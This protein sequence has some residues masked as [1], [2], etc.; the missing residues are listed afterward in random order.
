[1]TEPNY[2]LTYVE[3]DVPYCTLTYGASPCEATLT[4][5]NPTGTIK[6][7]NGLGTCQDRANFAESIVTLRFAQPADYLPVNDIEAIASIASVSYSPAVISLG[8]DLGQRASLKVTMVDHPHSDT[9]P[10]FDKYLSDRPYD[11][12]KLGTFWGKFRARHPYLRGRS[13]RLIQGLLGQ[14]LAEMDTRHFLIEQFDGPGLDGQFTITAKDALK[15]ADGDRAQA[16]MLSKGYLTAGITNSATSASLSPSGIGSEYPSSGYINVGGKEIVAF[17]RSGDA[18][19]LTRARFN[20]VAV[21][22]DAGDRCQLCLHYSAEDPADIIKDLMVTYAGVPSGYINIADWQAETGAYYRRVNTALIPEPTSVRTLLSELIEQDGLALWWDDAAETIRLQV[23]RQ[24]ATDAEA[25]SD[26]NVVRDTLKVR[27]QPGKRISQIWTYFG[28]FNPLNGLDPDNFRSAAILGDL[29]AE[30]DYGQP[31]IKKIFSRWIPFGGL[32]IANRVNSIQL[33]RYRTAP[34]HFTFQIFR[35]GAETPT[36]GEGSRLQGLPMQEA[37]GDLS[38]VPV[39]ITR[40]RPDDDIWEIE[41]E[42]QAFT[43][44]TDEDLSIH[45]ITID[46]TT[47]NVNLRDLHDDLYPTPVAGDEVL[48]IVNSGVNIGSVSTS[49]PAFDVG[50]WPSQAATGNRTSG[51]AVISSINIDV[52]AHPIEPGMFV[53]G[54]GIPNGT[55][56]LTVDSAHQV[57]LDANATSSGTGGAL[58]FYTVKITLDIRGRIQGKGGRGADGRAGGDNTYGYTGGTGGPG[59]YSRYP[60]TLAM[61]GYAAGGGGGGGGGGTDY[62]GWIG[63]QYNGGGGG[64][65]AGLGD[66]GNGATSEAGQPGDWT[67]G[68]I[69]GRNAENASGTVTLRAD[70]AGTGGAPGT[71]GGSAAG[72]FPGSG[73]PA[74]ASVDGWSYVKEGVVTGAYQGSKIN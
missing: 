56:V 38:S 42:E 33:A 41:A 70:R 51:S 20:T 25:Y 11:P 52:V 53:R 30:E 66:L 69:G 18:L 14:T 39:Q 63:P 32:T 44:T 49:L 15:L 46:S 65:G 54:T 67:T 16:P 59:L 27:E 34:R 8:E 73:G 45:P 58:T 43:V 26:A 68:G 36:L 48:C 5:P 24:V 29:D 61:T 55:K 2:A 12:F 72:L 40:L 10:G 23:L 64:G 19:T 21:A 74:G 37:T 6:C 9:G 3:I 7:F 22:H 71:T 4:G 62:I 13:L 35:R 1:M 31:A 47:F 60:I 28:I 50:S 17:T 57:T